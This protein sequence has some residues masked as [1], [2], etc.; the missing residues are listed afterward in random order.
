[1][2]SGF[3]RLGG[4]AV[5]RRTRDREVAGSTPGRGVYIPALAGIYTPL[6]AKLQQ[7]KKEE[8][9]TQYKATESHIK[10]AYKKY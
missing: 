6:F 5:R 9:N 3:G 8:K 2:H 1:M 7:I 10:H 4:A